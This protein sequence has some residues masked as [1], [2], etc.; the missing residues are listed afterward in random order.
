ML[1]I[2]E[3]K[4]LDLGIKGENESKTL[5]IDMSAWASLYPNAT[6]EI[7]HKRS[8]DSTK[9][10]TGAT[11]NSDTMI[12][13]WI[14][15]D[16]DTYYEGFGVAEIRMVEGDVVKKTKDLIVTAV[17]PSV[18]DGSG[19]IIESTYQAFLNS[20]ISTKQ[21]A[22]EA[23]NNAETAQGLA[24]DAAD[25]A[26]AYADDAETAAAAA[27]AAVTHGPYISNGN[28]NWMV[29]SQ[30]A[31]DYVD[32]GIHAQGPQGE[33]GQIENVRATGIKMSIV[34]DTTVYD[35]INAKPDTGDIPTK[36]S[37]LDNDAGYLT[38]H[39][40]ITGKA[41]KVSGATNNNFA[42][43]DENGNLK[44]SGHK[45]S[46]YLTSHQDI[47]GKAD[48]VSEATSGNF[49]G[50]DSNGNLTDSGHKH[51][52]YLTAHQDISGK[53]NQTELN[54]AEAGY[55]IVIDGNTAPK[56][57][58]SGQYLFIK[59]HSTLASGG[60][61]ATAAI[62]SGGSISSSNVAAD[63]DG[64]VNAAYTSLNSNTVKNTD[65]VIIDRNPSSTLSDC[66]DVTQVGMYRMISS[67]ANRPSNI[68][69]GVLVHLMSNDYLVQFV[70]GTN[71]VFA[72]R[73]RTGGNWT[74]WQ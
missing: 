61:H 11:Y 55:A 67:T 26:E 16:A 59:N 4:R 18:I 50:L 46:D 62:A 41:D 74:S 2:N 32:T 21:Q 73:G 19:T 13:T 31:G 36:V 30:D 40:D 14:P 60:Y 44:D 54:A 64:V 58:S 63:A 29:W 65:R 25:D 66:N 48:K 6:A 20:V 5:Q 9:A 70:I 34:D 39:Q 38:Q 42:A 47:T 12:L 43:L 49:A 72:S 45:H 10:L 17:C 33:P 68:S 23:K 53:A 35:A 52:D 56:A 69:Y 1:K 71:G 8:G 51:S 57:I 28:G 7:L 27:E 3:L 24:E 22:V 15:T 37:E